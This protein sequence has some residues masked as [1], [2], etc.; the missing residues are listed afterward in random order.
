M[1]FDLIESDTDVRW[2]ADARES[3]KEMQVWH[4]FSRFNALYH[5]CM[6]ASCVLRIY[7]LCAC[8]EKPVAPLPATQEWC[9][10]SLCLCVVTLLL[11]AL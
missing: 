9:T 1:N 7:V 6:H 10:G 8:S 4:L 5:T 11:Q 2:K 3:R